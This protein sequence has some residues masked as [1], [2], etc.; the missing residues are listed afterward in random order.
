MAIAAAYSAKSQADAQAAQADQA[1]AA[2][3]N[4]ANRREF[5]AEKE[6]NNA[7]QEKLN[8]VA[9]EH[10]ERSADKR[11]RALMESSYAKSGVILEGT[12]AEFLVEQETTDEL[13]VQRNNQVSEARR[14]GFSVNADLLNSEARWSRE[15]GDSQASA[16]RAGAQSTLIGGAVGALSSAA[17]GM[18]GSAGARQS[19]SAASFNSNGTLNY[20]SSDTSNLSSYPSWIKTG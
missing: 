8:R 16:Y 19:S 4:E 7:E 10:E 15:V 12:P 1:E 20:A 2:A 18:A 3:E 6:A 5:E 13:N 9:K 11:R 14:M 17:G